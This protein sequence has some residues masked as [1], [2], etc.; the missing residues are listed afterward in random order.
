MPTLAA[1][2]PAD[3]PLLSLACIG[4]SRF[5]RDPD[6]EPRIFIIDQI[7][8]RPLAPGGPALR[9]LTEAL[10]QCQTSVAIPPR[11]ARARP[12]HRDNRLV[13]DPANPTTDFF[14]ECF[15]TSRLDDNGGDPDAIPWNVT[16]YKAG[17]GD[18][19]PVYDTTNQPP[20]DYSIAQEIVPPTNDLGPTVVRLR[21]H[22]TGT[23]PL[24]KGKYV[25][26]L[27]LGSP[28]LEA[29]NTNAILR[30][31]PRF[32]L[33]VDAPRLTPTGLEPLDSPPS[34]TF[35]STFYVD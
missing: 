35:E 30:G 3:L 22:L 23:N 10:T 8:C 27:N 28:N 34:Y 7:N 1:C 21:F 29:L 15:S 20:T 14:A 32:P 2:P 19:P 6:T 33:L 18:D 26:R 17:S 4:W 16:F 13:A 11:F 31:L 5:A 9:A 25:W 24:P 12:R